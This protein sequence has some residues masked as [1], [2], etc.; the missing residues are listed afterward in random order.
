M[1]LE[2]T[3][4]RLGPVNGQTRPDGFYIAGTMAVFNVQNKQEVFRATATVQGITKSLDFTVGRLEGT[5]Y[6][7]PAIA[8]IGFQF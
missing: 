5:W 7:E 3:G 2:F 8:E 6:F 4:N 1:K